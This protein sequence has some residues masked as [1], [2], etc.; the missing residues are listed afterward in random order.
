[1]FLAW[2]WHFII[3]AFRWMPQEV[4][5]GKSSLVQVNGLLPSGNK[6]L[7]ELMLTNF[8]NTIWYHQG[9][10]SQHSILHQKWILLNRYSVEKGLI[11][12]IERTVCKTVASPRHKQWGYNNCP[13]SPWYI[14][15]TAS[16]SVFNQPVT[17][18]YLSQQKLDPHMEGT[19]KTQHILINIHDIILP[20]SQ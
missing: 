12:Y 1:M 20:F 10:I 18:I 3:I 5:Y 14:S 9:P 7:P 19:G 8:Y 15:T 17:F 13:P 16:S 11:H 2:R 6:P 4:R